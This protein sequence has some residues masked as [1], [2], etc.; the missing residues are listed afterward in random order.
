[1]KG[2]TVQSHRLAS[3]LILSLLDSTGVQRSI[4]GDRL[5]YQKDGVRAWADLV[6]HFETSSKDLRVES[7]TKK[8]DEATLEAGEHPDQLWIRLASINQNL[9]KL[10]EE[11]KESHFMRRFIAGI[12]TQ[13]GHPYKQVLT[14]YKGTVIAGSPLKINQMR[15]L[16]SETY[17]D[18][19][20]A[21]GRGTEENMKGFIVFKVCQ[22]CKKKGH[23]KESSWVAHPDKKPKAANINDRHARGNKEPRIICW[24]CGEP[25]HTKKECMKRSST[26]PQGIAAA[27]ASP[28]IMKNKPIYVDSACSCHLMVDVKY[29]EP[30][31]T[32]RTAETITAVGG[33]KI[34]L[35]QKG[36]V[37]IPT[38][39]GML[40]LT[41]TYYVQGL[42]FGLVSVPQLVQRGVSVYLT[43]EQAYLEKGGTKINLQ[44]VGDLWALPMKQNSKIVAL[45][46]EQEKQANAEKWHRRLGHIS[47]DKM[48]QLAKERMVPETA[49][50]YD[51]SRCEICLNMKPMRRSVTNVAKR[52]GEIVVQADYMPLG[53]GERGWKGEVGAYVY[54]CRTSKILKVYPV[55]NATAQ[56]AA[57]TLKDYLLNVTRHLKKKTTCIQT[58]AGSQFV[59]KEWV[60]VCVLNNI[61]DRSCPVDHQEMNGQVE[62]M[63]GILATKMRSLIMVLS[64]SPA[65][66][67]LGRHVQLRMCTTV[68]LPSSGGAGM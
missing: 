11:F 21:N 38:A 61:K 67:Q 50:Q 10:G 48:K 57:E 17:E 18:E 59:T 62:R 22:V 24:S 40:T 12:K 9:K 41:N 28:P 13:P 45:M 8:W 56:E 53:Q 15:E 49:A 36:T 27:I 39:D 26:N 66:P 68:Q 25:G 65:E 6:L 52:S 35:T 3:M 44:R 54:S 46:T 63:I 42:D 32:T 33:Q 29:F 43:K 64:P 55:R 19:K 23:T 30:N 5:R 14:M 4:V 16:L 31:T 51:A 20:A 37:K 60:S 2:A 34:D 7:L 47:T 1:M 58:D